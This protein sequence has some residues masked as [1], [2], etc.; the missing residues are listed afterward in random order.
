MDT[1]PALAEIQTLDIP[2]LIIGGGPAGMSAAVQLG[3]HGVRCLLVDDKDRLGGK[4]VL[5]THRFFGSIN[6]VYAGTRGID[7]A[8][9]LEN[10]VRQVKN[11]EIW[12]NST[13]LAV[14]SD[15][16]IGVLKEGS[17]YVLIRPQILLNT[18]FNMFPDSA[19]AKGVKDGQ[20]KQE[21]SPEQMAFAA[22]TQ[23]IHW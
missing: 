17:T 4:L 3:Q 16:V 12:L 7:I 9:R 6:A 21:L 14:F 22:L 15:K 10:E 19:A 20:A 23:G 5:Q 13:A 2:V 1:P 18:A 8:T 11:V